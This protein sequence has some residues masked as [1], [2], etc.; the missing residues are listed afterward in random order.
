M[1]QLITQLD[2]QATALQ[3]NAYALN[4]QKSINVALGSMHK[5]CMAT[6]LWPVHS[7]GGWTATDICRF[8]AWLGGQVGSY[9][10]VQ[11]YLTN[12][13]RIYHMMH[14]LPWKEKAESFGVTLALRGLKRVKGAGRPGQKLPITPELLLAIRSRLDF[15]QVNDISLWAACLVAFF[16][17]LRKSNYVSET[18]K[19]ATDPHILRRCDVFQRQGHQRLWLRLRCTKTIQFQERLL[20][21]PL[22][23]L[24]S[25]FLDPF[26]ALYVYLGVTRSRPATEW[27]FGRL[28]GKGRWRPMTDEWM[29]KRV[30]ELLAQSCPGIDT[31]RYGTHSFRRGGATYALRVGVSP[32]LIKM[33]GDWK[34]ECFY[35]YCSVDEELRE[36]A[37]DLLAEHMWASLTSGPTLSSAPPASA[38]PPPAQRD[39]NFGGEQA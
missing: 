16:G 1:A 4:S 28:D 26:T 19:G 7:A 15:T 38:G 11:N 27:L 33:M 36:V 35:E 37:A 10:T 21:L 39:D 14:N 30:R 24:P 31:S 3:A 25:H 2:A 13:P 18:E 5:F 17:F 29:M 23:C 34:S 9:D 20:E 12:G 8:I 22:P 32:V 6:G